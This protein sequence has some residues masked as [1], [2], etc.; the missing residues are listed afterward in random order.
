MRAPGRGAA[1]GSRSACAS[2]TP[3]GH[4]PG[5][6]CPHRSASA[7]RLLTLRPAPPI[8][9][10]RLTGSSARVTSPR[11]RTP[12]TQ[13]SSRHADDLRAGPAPFLQPPLR[14]TFGPKLSGWSTSLAGDRPSGGR[15][16][17]PASL[18]GHL[19][20]ETLLQASGFPCG[21]PSSQRCGVSVLGVAHSAP[22]SPKDQAAN[23]KYRAFRQDF[24]TIPRSSPG[25]STRSQS[26]LG[27][28]SS[29]EAVERGSRPA[30]PAR[31]GAPASPA[32]PA[33]FRRSTARRRGRPPRRS[34]RRRRAPPRACAAAA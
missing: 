19:P 21:L 26:G 33:S 9:K 11:R 14:A 24:V 18:A 5:N 30:A 25:S 15:P 20:S 16:V 28:V 1:P 7:L 32:D 34:D 29:A 3:R 10:D 31:P 4:A 13:P 27:S 6:L 23:A 22:P 17:V 2:R 12:L 8:P